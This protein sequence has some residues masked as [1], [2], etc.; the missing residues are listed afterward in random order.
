ML[1]QNFKYLMKKQISLFFWLFTIPY[2]I[3][4]WTILYYELFGPF[5][6]IYYLILIIISF[7]IIINF[8]IKLDICS[9]DF[10]LNLI[11]INLLAICCFMA[12]VVVIPFIIILLSYIYKF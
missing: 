12:T 2:N 5:L 3:M 4:L 7:K 6:I 11:A 10:F 8:Y 9:N 1:Q